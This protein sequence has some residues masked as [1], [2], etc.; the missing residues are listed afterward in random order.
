MSPFEFLHFHFYNLI[1]NLKNFRAGRHCFEGCSFQKAKEKFFKALK[2]LSQAERN[3]GDT[4]NISCSVED[5]VK[6]VNNKCENCP[7]NFTTDYAKQQENP[8]IEVSS[9]VLAHLPLDMSRLSLKEPSICDDQGQDYHFVNLD[10]IVYALLSDIL[11]SLA[12]CLEVLGDF[13]DSRRVYDASYRLQQVR[14]TSC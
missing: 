6:F 2:N 8:L 7:I 12:C 5:I 14:C 11:T 9:A 1:F 13:R 3:V 10:C 4:P